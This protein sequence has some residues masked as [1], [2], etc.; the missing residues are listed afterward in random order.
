MTLIDITDSH[1]QTVLCFAFFSFLFLLF[2]VSF[3]Y[4]YY[5]TT[6]YNTAMF[7]D[8]HIILHCIPFTW[9]TVPATYKDLEITR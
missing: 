2:Q 8:L 1:I 3:N 7:Y 5:I 9:L 4:V 6:I